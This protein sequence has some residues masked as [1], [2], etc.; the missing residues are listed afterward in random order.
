MLDQEFT[1]GHY[2]ILLDKKL[3]SGG[4]GDIFFGI[5][6]KTG[7]EVAVKVES[8]VSKSPQ[9]KQETNLLLTLQGGVGIPT[10][11]YYLSTNQYNFMIIDLL[12][13][14]IQAILDNNNLNE[15]SVIVMSQQMLQRIEFMHSRHLI[16][17]D[18]KPDNFLLGVAKNK[19]LL[20]LIDYGLS[21]RFRDPKTGEHINY[22]D[23]KALTGTT[24][25]ASIYT[26]LGIE[27]SRR[28]DLECMCYAMIYM[29]KKKL[30]WQGLKVKN[31]AEKNI[32]VMNKKISCSP[33][34]LCENLPSELS[35]LLEYIRA[36]NF[37]EKPDYDYM[38]KLLSLA[39]LKL[40]VDMS[41]SG[42]W[43]NKE[44]LIFDR[45]HL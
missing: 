44:N 1:I 9:L 34:Y 4:F 20:Y 17:R 24:R 36:L 42:D 27:Q 37:E 29:F 41:Y 30:P 3:G 8:S 10:L 16:H 7:E 39:S 25:Y 45:K 2:K 38:Q 23:K 15:K 31:S 11:H 14:S 12:G 21:K 40:G 13:P 43:C 18:I 35:T 33:E 5:N 28:D 19:N 22:K 26:H 32:K 6:L